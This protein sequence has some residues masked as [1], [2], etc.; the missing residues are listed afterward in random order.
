M[1]YTTG[2]VSILLQNGSKDIEKDLR[3]GAIK[4]GAKEKFGMGLVQIKE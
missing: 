1:Q 4:L 3:F 2:I